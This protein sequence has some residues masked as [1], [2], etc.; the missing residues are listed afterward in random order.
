MSFLTSFKM[1][2]LQD[3]LRL[4]SCGF[5]CEHWAGNKLSLQSHCS[6]MSLY[7]CLPYPILKF[8]GGF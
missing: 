7:F 2:V 6:F 5:L 4:G 8:E 3:L 1:T